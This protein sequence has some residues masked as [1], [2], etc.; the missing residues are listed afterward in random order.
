MTAYESSTIDVE[1]VD[2][3]EPNPYWNERTARH[4][5]C[6]CAEYALPY[7]QDDQCELLQAVVDM[8]RAYADWPEEWAGERKAAGDAAG[9]AWAAARDTAGAAARAAWAA[10]WAAGDTA[11]AA[12][13]AART[14]TWAAGATARDDL[15][16]ILATYL[17][18]TNEWVTT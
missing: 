8:A 17:D 7:A 3:D 11:G 6:D 12:A 2:N 13:W 4:F 15:A 14:A 9:A 18:G 10:A 16:A 5:A 1:L